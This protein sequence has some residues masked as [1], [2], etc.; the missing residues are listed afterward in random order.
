MYTCIQRAPKMTQKDFLTVDEI[1]ELLR[2]SASS[3][4]NRLSRGD[5]TL[6]PSLRVGGRRLFPVSGY[7]RWIKNMV[8]PHGHD[9]LTKQQ[10]TPDILQRRGRPRQTSGGLA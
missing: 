10:S 5:P 3:V 2:V 9:Q 6:P 8:E 1:A 7:E 4:R